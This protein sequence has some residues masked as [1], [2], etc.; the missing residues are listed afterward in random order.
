MRGPRVQH[1][2]QHGHG[3]DAKRPILRVPRR[4]VHHLD[5]RERDAMR[6]DVRHRRLLRRGRALR[7]RAVTFIFPRQR[8]RR[9]RRLHRGDARAQDVHDVVHPA[10]SDR[11]VAP[12]RRVQHARHRVRDGREQ[13]RVVH[14][15]RRE[16]F[17][18]RGHDAELHGL[19]L[20]E[21]VA[22]GVREARGDVRER[23]VRG[24]H[25]LEHG[26]EHAE[27]TLLVRRVSGLR[28]VPQRELPR[29]GGV[30]DGRDLRDEP[31]A[32]LP[33]RGRAALAHVRAEVHDRLRGSDRVR[34]QTL[35]AVEVVLVP[36]V[37]PIVRGGRAR[38]VQRAVHLV[39]ARLDEAHAVL[40]SRRA[41]VV[42]ADAVGDV[43][44]PLP[45]LP[46]GRVGGVVLHPARR[47]SVGGVGSGAPRE[48]GPRTYLK[49]WFT[50]PPP[51]RCRCR[52]WY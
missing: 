22:R 1:A 28:L 6:V 46:V 12:F 43:P 23:D 33:A 26:D 3:G 32:N 19:E 51:T 50:A 18:Q 38:A 40:R 13:L 30:V 2:R 36:R 35:A 31:G 45:S 25:L 44:D 4:A 49:S 37:R 15:L 47:Q 52:L 42:R 9:R 21:V 11:L 16:Q 29:P 39:G 14:I 27:Q 8:R 48:C 7:E 34:F 20:N 5:R 24:V 10:D 17:Y 41:L